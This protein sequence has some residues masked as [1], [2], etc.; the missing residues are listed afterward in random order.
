MAHHTPATTYLTDRQL[1]ERYG[2]SRVTIWRWARSG[3][4]PA[5]VR[6][7]ANTTRWRSDAVAE[8][9]RQAAGG[10]Q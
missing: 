1:A 9:E 4:L 8:A 5:P 2:V 10:D 3:R 6:L 7:G